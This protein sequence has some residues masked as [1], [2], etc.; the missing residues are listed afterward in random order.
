MDNRAF[1]NKDLSNYMNSMNKAQEENFK[2]V[3][4]E[5]LDWDISDDE[6]LLEHIERKKKEAL[7][8]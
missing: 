8:N 6:T 1:K 7:L 5:D 2:R 4:C 3:P